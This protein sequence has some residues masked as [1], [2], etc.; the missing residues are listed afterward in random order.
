MNLYRTLPKF[1]FLRPWYHCKRLHLAVQ[2]INQYGI[3]N[4]KLVDKL[5]TDIEEL[6]RSKNHWIILA[7]KYRYK[8]ESKHEQY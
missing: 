1:W 7:N 5:E 2:A 4:E 3:S 8:Y 6:E